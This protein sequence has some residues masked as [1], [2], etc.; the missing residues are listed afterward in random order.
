MFDKFFYNNSDLVKESSRNPKILSMPVLTEDSDID[1]SKD[2][3]STKND[4]QNSTGLKN[5]FLKCNE[6]WSYYQNNYPKNWNWPKSRI[7]KVLIGLGGMW[8]W[9]CKKVMKGICK[10][11]KLIFSLKE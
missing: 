4:P 7:G 9:K 11:K 8:C 1:Q 6:E 3:L 2:S 5:L 10:W